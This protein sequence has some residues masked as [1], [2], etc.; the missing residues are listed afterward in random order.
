MARAMMMRWRSPPERVAPP[1]KVRTTGIA[2]TN[3]TTATFTCSRAA[4]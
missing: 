4:L 1:S 2:C 3:S